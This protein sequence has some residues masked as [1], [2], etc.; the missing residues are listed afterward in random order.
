MEKFERLEN[1]HKVL[2]PRV[3]Q[4]IWARLSNQAKRND[5]RLA[6]VQKVLVKIGAILAH[7]AD[8]LPGTYKWEENVL[9]GHERPT[10][11][12]N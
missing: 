9:R 1:C 5:L 12:T 8:R 7:S 6:S 11:L 10:G 3:N 4:E 2:V